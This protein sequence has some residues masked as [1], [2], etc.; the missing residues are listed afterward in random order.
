MPPL[1]AVLLTPPSRSPHPLRS[2]SDKQNAADHPWPATFARSVHPADPT[3]LSF[4]LFS[5]TCALLCTSK[6]LNSLLF[7]RFRTPCTEHPGVGEVS[8]LQTETHILSTPRR[9]IFFRIRTSKRFAFSGPLIPLESAHTFH[10]RLRKFF[11]IR[12]SAISA[13]N[14]FRIRTSEKRWGGGCSFLLYPPFTS[15]LPYTL[16]SSVSCKSFVSHS[17]ENCR[18]GGLFFPFWNST[19]SDQRSYLPLCSASANGACGDS[20]RSFPRSTFNCRLSTVD[21][22]PR[23]NTFCWGCQRDA[24]VLA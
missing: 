3:P 16:P 5:T 6:K 23:E 18:G 17:Y 9:S 15:I 19:P 24:A 11:R 2:P 4:L 20:S 21:C 22:Q 14:P 1:R 13:L 8:S 12:T 10:A 7:N